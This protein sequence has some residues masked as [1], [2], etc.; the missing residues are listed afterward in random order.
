MGNEKEDVMLEIYRLLDSP[1]KPKTLSQIINEGLEQLGLSKHQ[2]ALIL[3]I[4]SSTFDRIITNINNNDLKD[5]DFDLLLKLAQ[6]LAVSIDEISQIYVASLTSEKI[7]EIEDARKANYILNTFDV[8]ALKKEGFIKSIDFKHIEERVVSFFGLDSIFQYSN[9]IGGVLFSRTK[10]LS[11]D[12]MREMWV[13]S[14][15]FQ[16]QKIDN[17]NAFDKEK[18]L[19]IIPKIR[20]YTRYE[21]KGL[22]TV[23]QALY[24]IGVTV[25]VQSYLSKTQ[26]RGGTFVING[27]PCIVITDYNK[28]YA[29]LW[30]ALL[31]EIYHALY[32]FE[33]L[34]TL[35]YHLTG[36]EQS[37]IYLFK[38]DMADYFACEMLFPKENLDYIKHMIKSPVLVDDYAEKCK[39]HP[40]IIYSFYCFEQKKDGKDHYPFYRKHFGKSDKAIQVVKTHPWNKETIYEEIEK[41][42]K[43][44]TPNTTIE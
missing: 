43:I 3:N 13:R 25:I 10:N 4:P 44:L 2:L 40:S 20:P 29:T 6:F 18:L 39:V 31:H 35:T 5:V 33:E 7:K 19:G 24:N 11:A 36:E 34:K 17:P 37:E 32:D 38:E 41:V 8:K 26:V 1:V 16:F 42:K 22:L 27:K 23:L 15:I 9:E 12:K 21:E 14:A 28:T 30:F